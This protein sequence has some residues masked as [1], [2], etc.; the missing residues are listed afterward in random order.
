MT[1][2]RLSTIAL[3]AAAAQH[4]VPSRGAA[5]AQHAGVVVGAFEFTQLRFCT[6]IIPRHHFMK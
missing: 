1:T 2:R 4:D 5:V 6:M 3:A